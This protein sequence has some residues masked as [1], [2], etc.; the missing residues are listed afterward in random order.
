MATNEEVDPFE[1]CICRETADSVKSDIEEL[2]EFCFMAI[3]R[4]PE[5]C[6]KISETIFHKI[7]EEIIRP[8]EM[9][10]EECDQDRYKSTLLESEIGC[11][12]SNHRCVC[13]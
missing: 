11:E 3:E 6:R 2:K 4:R 10:G 12:A 1:G 5:L 9:L 8:L 7:G 13:D